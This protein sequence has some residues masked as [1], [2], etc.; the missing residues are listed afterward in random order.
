MSRKSESFEPI[1]QIGHRFS[2]GLFD[3]VFRC[4][5]V[6]ADNV[7]KT[8]PYLIA[9]NHVSYFDPFIIGSQIRR[10]MYFFARKTLFKPGFG[11]WIMRKF[12]SIPVD[13]GGDSDVGAL[14]NV[15]KILQEGEGLLLFPE[16][17]RS[18]DGNLQSAKRGVGM[19]A[20]R[21]AVPVVPVRVFGAFDVWK[22]G[23]RFPNLKQEVSVAYG[24]PLYPADFDL[25]KQNPDR[26]QIAADRVLDAI[27]QL[28][29]PVIPQI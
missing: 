15:F 7:P 19:I 26:Y 17:T 4:T 24:K 29:P 10:Q 14:K 20:C 1:Y 9:S 2:Y 12:H 16:G 3:L 25:G 6:G 8:G 13:L 27:G 18:K 21:A 5:S 11:D 23:E 28:T 22:K